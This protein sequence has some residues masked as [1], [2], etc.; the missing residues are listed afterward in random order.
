MSL[1]EI[2]VF[3]RYVKL[4]IIREK[5]GTILEKHCGTPNQSFIRERHPVTEISSSTSIHPDYLPVRAYCATREFLFGF[6]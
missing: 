2:R 4:I 5:L 6:K 3:Y 1:Q